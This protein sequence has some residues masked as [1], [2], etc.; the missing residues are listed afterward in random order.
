MGCVDSLAA[1]IRKE[2]LS[3]RDK[4]AYVAS[5]LKVIAETFQCSVLITNQMPV[6]KRSAVDC[7]PRES[8]H[9]NRSGQVDVD[10]MGIC[11]KFGPTWYHSVSI[12]LTLDRI[13]FE[14]EGIDVY[15]GKRDT[16]FQVS[17]VQP[18]DEQMDAH[19]ISHDG[20]F[21]NKENSARHVKSIRIA[22]SS[23]FTNLSTSIIIN[24]CGISSI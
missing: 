24:N 11:A 6:L 8:I 9:Q 23:F 13:D 20:T 14:S 2:A 19:I 16:P 3:D 1:L 21:N 18:F 22:K 10:N 7:L 5:T 4:C 17:F 15:S 12:R